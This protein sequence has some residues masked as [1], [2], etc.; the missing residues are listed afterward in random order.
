VEDVEGD[1]NLPTHYGLIHRF[2]VDGDGNL[3]L[4]CVA[5]GVK[6]LMFQGIR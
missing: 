4:A 6:R 1:I 5:R 2:N 3:L